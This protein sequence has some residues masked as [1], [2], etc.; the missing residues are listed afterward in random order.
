MLKK[1]PSYLW[2]VIIGFL[3]ISTYW[4]V[5]LLCI[6]GGLFWWWTVTKSKQSTSSTKVND[7]LLSRLQYESSSAPVKESESQSFTESTDDNTLGR[8]IVNTSVVG[9]NYENREKIIED[10]LSDN[11]EPYWGRTNAELKEDEEG[12]RVYKYDAVEEYDAV[13]LVPEPTNKYDPNAIKVVHESIGHI[14]YIPADTTVR[15]KKALEKNVTIFSRVY[16]GPYKDIFDG[17]V[18]TSKSPFKVAIKIYQ[19]G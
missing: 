15:V 5:G 9:I 3:L 2:L 8:C 7:N 6:V 13:S 17:R 1:V 19:K 18:S 10:W 14:G 11:F 12:N 16:G 4:F